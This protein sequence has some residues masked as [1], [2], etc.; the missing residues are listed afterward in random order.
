MEIEDSYSGYL[1][2]KC[3]FIPLIKIVP[4]NN[5][6]KIFSS[7]KCCKCYE[8][9]DTFIKNK[10]QKN[11]VDINIIQNKKNFKIYNKNEENINIENIINNLNESKNILNENAI[12][13]KNEIIELYKKKIEKINNLYENYIKINNKIELIL[14]HI[15]NSYNL[16]KDNQSNILNILNNCSFNNS[17]KKIIYSSYINLDSLF[18]QIETYYNNEFIISSSSIKEEFDKNYFSYNPNYVQ[19]FIE[20]DNNLCAACFNNSKDISIYSL[21][22]IEKNKELFNFSA[23]IK[24][25]NWI[26]KSNKNNIISCGYDGLIK[27]WPI[28]DDKFILKDLTNLKSNHIERN[29]IKLEPIYEYKYENKEMK[30]IIK[31]VDINDNRFLAATKANIFLFKYIIEEKNINIEFIKNY[32]SYDLIDVNIIKK[33]KNE[34]IVLNTHYFLLFLNIPNLEIISKIR[35]S[36]QCKNNLIQLNSNEILISKGIELLIIDLNKYKTKLKIKNRS[37]CDYLLNMND[38]TILLV[39]FYEIKRL[40]IKTMEELPI[41]LNLNNE[42]NDEYYTDYYGDYYDC[43]YNDKIVYIYKLKD[44]RFILCHCNGTINI[45]KIKFI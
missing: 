10:Y 2:K 8:D 44:G 30:E 45:C 21:T 26:I 14:K 17:S 28:I 13:I 20:L 12:K 33:D 16:F 5:N 32:T 9:I 18:K 31:M 43:H 39:D 27:I 36:L 3:N 37:N 1:C 35:V 19:N 29:K 6:I 34:I 24:F 41:L 38:G 25:V 23:H 4:R 11:M 40:L 15:I 42:Y 22:E 7:C